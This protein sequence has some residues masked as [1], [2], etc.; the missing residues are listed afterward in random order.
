MFFALAF[1]D[2]VCLLWCCFSTPLR[3]QFYG[4]C[5]AWLDAFASAHKALL[6][7]EMSSGGAAGS[8]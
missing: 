4:K 6:R 1:F 3:E 2:F 5:D 8:P 7:S